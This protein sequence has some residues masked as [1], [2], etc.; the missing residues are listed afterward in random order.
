MKKLNTKDIP[1]TYAHNEVSRK[2]LVKV[3]D[4]K[5]KLQTVNDAHLKPVQG[6]S[7]H[8]HPDCEEIYYLKNTSQ[9]QNLR[10]LTI[11][12]LL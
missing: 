10:F 3:G 11:R 9:T 2:T 7:P 1:T 8:T 5:S 6:F 12:V 4:L